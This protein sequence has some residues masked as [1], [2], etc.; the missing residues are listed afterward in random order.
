MADLDSKSLEQIGYFFGDGNDSK[1]GQVFVQLNYSGSNFSQSNNGSLLQ[2]AMLCQNYLNKQ[3]KCGD[4]H[5]IHPEFVNFI[6]HTALFHAE[7]DSKTGG[8]NS[9]NYLNA[10]EPAAK[11]LINRVFKQWS[12][13]EN[14]VRIFYST[15]LNAFKNVNGVEVL[16]DNLS[17]VEPTAEYRLNLKKIIGN[18]GL[19]GPVLFASTLPLVPETSAQYNL[20]LEPNSDPSSTPIVANAL[21][22]G[23]VAGVAAALTASP[24]PLNPSTAANI[25]KS[26]NN[27]AVLLLEDEQL[28]LLKDKPADKEVLRSD[29][30]IP[31]SIAPAIPRPKYGPVPDFSS[32]KDFINKMAVAITNDEK[33]DLAITRIEQ[34]I[35]HGD[36]SQE[37]GKRQ[38]E[39]IRRLNTVPNDIIK[40]LQG[41][42]KQAIPIKGD[43]YIL[44]KL[45][46]YA[47]GY[48][49]EIN[50]KKSTN[51]SAYENVE[52][53]NGKV[54]HCFKAVNGSFNLNEDFMIRQQLTSHKKSSGPKLNKKDDCLDAIDELF[55]DMSS[56]VVYKRGDDGRLYKDENGKEVYVDDSVLTQGNKCFSTGINPNMC[57]GFMDCLKLKKG[58][59]S[60]ERCIL[61]LSKDGNS[62]M[63]IIAENDIKNTHPDVIKDLLAKFGVMILNEYDSGVGRII[64]KYENFN[65]WLERTMKHDK[66][67]ANNKFKEGNLVKYIKSL[68]SIVKANPLILNDDLNN[69]K[70]IL[71]SNI[72]PKEWESLGLKAYRNPFEGKNLDAMV[73]SATLLNTIPVYNNRSITAP[74]FP[75]GTGFA[76]SSAGLVMGGG[77][78]MYNTMGKKP[79]EGSVE[80]SKLIYGMFVNAFKELEL[81]N[82]SLDENDKQNIHAALSRLEKLESQLVKIY[83]YMELFNKL[84]KFVNASGYKDNEQKVVKLEDLKNRYDNAEKLGLD[85]YLK[86]ALSDLNLSLDKNMNQQGFICNKLLNGIYPAVIQV[87]AGKTSSLIV[88][89]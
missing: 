47:Y 60:F 88:P 86:N 87:A 84:V 9:N 50:Y 24:G 30:S 25:V 85:G 19:T 53:Y 74:L 11:D 3:D 43:L 35:M 12:T 31:P 58:E 45:Y 55:L 8:I 61:D 26:G 36:L 64:N 34:N 49:F 59:D 14:D 56:G 79:G 23:L 13:I 89:V 76:F 54:R 83:K 75:T 10:T 7:I 66:I 65:I 69:A 27:S 1:L 32:K 44:Q 40:N 48:G 39:E 57:S 28:L 18:N 72:L 6:I 22:S 42:G 82:K 5:D 51:Y 67:K 38:I 37:E 29:K 41:G 68:M 17:Q 2:N 81:N 46:L 33:I 62:N 71:P 16:L 21:A 63:F 80:N 15:F 78:C 73:Y 70:L 4:K 52:K 77:S 20:I